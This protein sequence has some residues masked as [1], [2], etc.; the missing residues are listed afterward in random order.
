MPHHVST[1]PSMSRTCH[2]VVTS[3]G[4]PGGPYL[5]C[6]ARP[7][8]VR[9]V[10]TQPELYTA[11]WTLLRTCIKRIVEAD[12]LIPGAYNWIYALVTSTDAPH[13]PY[14][15]STAADVLKAGNTMFRYTLTHRWMV[16]E[17]TIDSRHDPQNMNVGF[18]TEC[19]K[20]RSGPA[21]EQKLKKCVRCQ[22]A[23]Y[24]SRQCQQE[25][26]RRHQRYCHK[27]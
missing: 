13:G 23:R 12:E 16:A 27:Q 25:D 22:T 1:L 19:W 20:C 14:A 4:A 6:Y 9:Q 24:C 15:V 18:H 26:W 8:G 7:S 21:V 2:D 17:D 3:E 5:Q 10:D 11:I